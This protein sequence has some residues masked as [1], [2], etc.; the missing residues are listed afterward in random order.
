MIEV[1]SV[2]E[3]E[4][5]DVVVT[6]KEFPM[7]YICVF[8]S[9]GNMV[10]PADSLKKLSRIQEFEGAYRSTREDLV[11]ISIL[12]KDVPSPTRRGHVHLAGSEIA[13]VHRVGGAEWA[14]EIPVLEK[15]GERWWDRVVV[16]IQDTRLITVKENLLKDFSFEGAEE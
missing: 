13:P 5:G 7:T 15:D 2:R 4:N 1:H 6:F 9:N 3:L 8:D 10:L 12:S 16:R 14:V 11:Y